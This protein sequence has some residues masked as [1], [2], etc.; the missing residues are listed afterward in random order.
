MKVLVGEDNEGSVKVHS[1]LTA[2]LL[3]GNGHYMSGIVKI[4]RAILSPKVRDDAVREDFPSILI[5][6]CHGKRERLDGIKI[7]RRDC[8][9]DDSL[10]P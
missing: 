5:L 2:L 4:G 8:R 7:S 3:V 1:A 6:Q 9:R 10:E